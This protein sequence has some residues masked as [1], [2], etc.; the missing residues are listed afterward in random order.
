MSMSSFV[1]SWFVLMQFT[2]W[3][4][5][6][7]L[8]Y[9]HMFHWG[10]IEF[11]NLRLFPLFHTSIASTK[12]YPSFEDE[13]FQGGDSVTSHIFWASFQTA[14][15]THINLNSMIPCWYIWDYKLY[16]VGIPLKMYWGHKYLLT[17][18]RV[19]NFSIDLVFSECF[20][21]GSIF[22]DH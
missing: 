1:M 12:S 21:L 2:W 6:D 19:G 17:Q 22:N 10:K 15:R 9:L 8:E 7:L 14:G 20:Q 16:S 11:H 4:H 13:W 3:C 5:E 18:R